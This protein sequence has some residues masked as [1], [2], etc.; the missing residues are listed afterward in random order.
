MRAPT[1]VL[2]GAAALA[3]AATPLGAASPADSVY[4]G[5]YVYTVDA[6][7]GVQQAL[8]V[9]AGRIIYV[10]DE[11]GARAL[12]G[13]HTR[14]FDLAGRMLMPGLID[15]H[16]HPLDGGTGLRKC[17]LNYERLTVAE[18][19]QRIQKCLDETRTRE[20]DGWLEVVNWFREA[21]LPAGVATSRATLDGL[22]T[23]RPIFVM[24][25]FGH[26][27]LV[28]SRALELAKLSAASHDPL[29]G[30]IDREASGAP[31]GIL[32][33]DAAFDLVQKLIPGATPAE[34]AQAAR[35]ALQAVNAQG[36]TQF[37]DAQATERTVSAFAAAQRDGG[38]SA[39]AH[40]ALWITPEE[41][42]HAR[43]AIAR[44]QS[45]A[46]R[47][48]QG[49]LRPEP[50][51]TVRN[52]KLFMDG[53]IT[54]PALTGAMLRPYLEDRG[55]PAEPRWVPSANRG[56][57]VYFPPPLLQ[58]LLLGAARAGLEPH[59]HVDGDRAV[60]E[61]LEG[62]AALRRA[63]PGRMI[64]A[65]LAHDESVDPADFARF[66][67]LDAIPVLSFQWE[68]PAPDSVDGAREY[69]GPARY[70]YIEPAGYLAAAG[71]RIAYGSDWPV[72]RLDEW[73]A[74]KVGVTRENDP[75]EAGEKYRGRLSSDPGLTVP[76]VLRAITA[77][78]A[79]EL[80]AD[81]DTG[82]LEVGKLADFIVLDRNPLQIDPH[83]IA[84][85]RV[86]RTVV[87]DKT[88]YEAPAR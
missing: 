35:L 9:R 36:V 53:V 88:V 32:E 12:I 58:A 65:A 72:D 56:P 54:A 43:A 10:G 28:N 29:G 2:G 75:A 52:I 61:A 81:A 16:M 23:R 15:G 70:R 49:P 74:L 64:R 87:G 86:L 50:T 19:Q 51:L 34:D 42:R 44:V 62:V 20:P 39:R 83:D 84:H 37:L 73:F 13:P 47:Y 82:S 60:H 7:D 33:E 57:E 5:G 46:R 24:S 63:F 6:H 21:M 59:L 18:L 30:R 68:K 31:S 69:L 3:L 1:K 67:A 55:T 17:N 85:V 8:A 71:A 25:S 45:L 4:L 26:T 38:L 78:A 48:D 80:H 76:A 79:Y 27:A 22:Q 77:N 14:R 11:A 40:F 66:G 41:G